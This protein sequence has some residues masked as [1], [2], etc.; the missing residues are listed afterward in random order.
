MI[1]GNK[2]EMREFFDKVQSGE[3]LTA[4]EQ[5]FLDTAKKN[6]GERGLKK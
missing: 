3:I 2:T 5:A 1:F 6:I 4:K